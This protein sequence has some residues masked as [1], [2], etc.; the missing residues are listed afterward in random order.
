[1]SRLEYGG[2]RAAILDF[3]IENRPSS[4]L[5]SDF[6][7]AEIT[8]ISAKFVGSAVSFCW[9][10]GRDDMRKALESFTE[11]V[12]NADLLTGHYIR[13]HDLP[14][15]NG[16]LARHKL[17]LLGTVMTEDTKNDFKYAAG[18]SKSQENLG[19]LFGLPSSKF[20]MNAALWEQANGM[21]GLGEITAEGLALTEERV[22][23]DVNMHIQLRA[24]LHA[25]RY[26]CG[27][28]VWG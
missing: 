8:A 25:G 16:S 23:S 6:T 15:I 26:L 5:G 27:P 28:K 10:L 2:H 19:V 11:L 24:R 22:T 7:T 4:Y 13:Q 20:H 21:Y 12:R 17:P 18:L 1:M 3:D 9:M 14:I